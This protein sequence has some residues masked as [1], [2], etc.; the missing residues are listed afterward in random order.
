MDDLEGRIIAFDERLT[1]LMDLIKKL[2][3]RPVVTAGAASDFDADY[4]ASK[5]DFASLL[6]RV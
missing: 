4:F 3:D 5:D 2:E 1:V 6:E